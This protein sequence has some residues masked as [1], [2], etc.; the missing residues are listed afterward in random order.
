MLTRSAQV[1]MFTRT[2]LPLKEEMAVLSEGKRS[3]EQYTIMQ[4]ADP[5]MLKHPKVVAM[6]R[7]AS[8]GVPFSESVL[9]LHGFCHILTQVIA[10]K[11]NASKMVALNDHKGNTVHSG[12]MVEGKIL[13]VTGLNDPNELCQYYMGMERANSVRAVSFDS[14]ELS[15]YTMAVDNNLHGILKRT[16]EVADIIISTL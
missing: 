10:N 3:P 2:W 5:A 13:D 12:V 1:K 8:L 9:Y 15:Q 16:E 14:I 7:Y 11:L 6:G 4:H